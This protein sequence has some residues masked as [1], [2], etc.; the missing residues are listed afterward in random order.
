MARNEINALRPWVVRAVLWAALLAVAL[1]VQSSMAGEAPAP[2]LRE[3][4]LVKAVR[5]TRADAWETRSFPGVA[6]VDSETDLSFRVGGPLI[7]VGV[8]TG[9]RVSIGEIIARIDPRDFL[10][11]IQRQE[12]AIAQA[13]AN[14]SAMKTGAR[15]EDIA[16]MEANLE[17]AR[18]QLSE[19]E[20]NFGRYKTL[21]EEKAVARA[22]FDSARTG[23]E[24]AQAQVTAAQKGLEMGRSG[25]RKE[26]VEA[27]EAQVRLLRSDLEAAKNALGDTEL[28]SPIQG[29]VNRKYV[30]NYETVAPGHPIVSLL[31]LSSMQVRTSVPQTLMARMADW[32]GFAC[33]FDAHPGVTLPGELEE[34]G[35]KTEGPGMSYPLIV[36]VVVPGGLVILPGMAAEVSISL[37]SPEEERPALYLPGSAIFAG[38]DGEPSVWKIDSSA[39]TVSRARVSTGEPREEGVLILDGV[40]EGDL[41][42]GA[43][44]RFLREGEKIRLLDG[45]GGAAR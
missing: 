8:K 4:R 1:P 44:A 2:D 21:Y 32:K 42:V 10:L 5:V 45:K 7:S 16:R 41:V 43:G 15:P 39:M 29:M 6:Q 19:A 23:R 38:S 40:R 13:M 27:M 20:S 25:A 17:A 34:I 11:N 36:Q 9:Q 22:A 35:R 18:A 14:L 31:D 12:A 24:N 30:D 37:R 26:D 33:S 3:T 28:R